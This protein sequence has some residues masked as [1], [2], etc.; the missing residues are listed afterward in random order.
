MKLELTRA[1]KFLD[2][3]I[4][5]TAFP[6]FNLREGVDE[7]NIGYTQGLI[8]DNIPFAAEIWKYEDEETLVVYLPDLCMVNREEYI[9]RNLDQLVD[10]HDAL[11]QEEP[12]AVYYDLS[13]LNRFMTCK[14]IEGIFEINEFY[15]E[16]LEQIGIIEFTSNVQ[17]GYVTYYKDMNG[18]KVI[19]FS[20]VLSKGANVIAKC[21]LPMTAFEKEDITDECERIHKN[22]EE[23]DEVYMECHIYVLQGKTYIMSLESGLNSVMQF[24]KLVD[25]GIQGSIEIEKSWNCN[26]AVSIRGEELLE[27]IRRIYPHKYSESMELIKRGWTYTIVADDFS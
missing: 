22:G 21:L 27:F 17:N 9:E 26:R 3:D 1:N 19:A 12:E 6:V 23:L 5:R 8:G 14:F 25:E 13:V 7:S 18:L 11:V 24:A 2:Y 16:Y 4:L 10:E 20:V 15:K